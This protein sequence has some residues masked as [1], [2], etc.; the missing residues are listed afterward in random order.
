[1]AYGIKLPRSLSDD[2]LNL[3]QA[4]FGFAHWLLCLFRLNFPL[5]RPSIL[6]VN[7]GDFAGRNTGI[8]KILVVLATGIPEIWRYSALFGDRITGILQFQRITH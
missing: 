7:Y 2:S 6:V 3:V 5:I 4:P 1:M 8:P